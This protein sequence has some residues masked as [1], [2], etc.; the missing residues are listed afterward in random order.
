M[1]QMISAKSN[2]EDE[3]KH[4]L[5]NIIL[6]TEFNYISERINGFYDRIR[7]FYNELN[8]NIN[9]ARQTIINV[10]LLISKLSKSETL[11]TLSNTITDNIKALH[12]KNKALNTEKG[13]GEI[14][15]LIN[16]IKAVTEKILKCQNPSFANRKELEN[17]K[18]RLAQKE[19]S[20]NEYK[21]RLE[22]IAKDIATQEQSI[23]SIAT[24]I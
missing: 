19:I 12:F 23:N 5:S 1:Q 21:A 24:K 3:V 9:E 15:S 7:P 22:L 10:D 8:K 4:A 11:S 13:T 14:E 18:K 2:N 16:Q 17:A 20:Y 6:G